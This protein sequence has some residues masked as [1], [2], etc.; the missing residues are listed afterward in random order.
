[1]PLCLSTVACKGKGKKSFLIQ[2]KTHCFEVMDS[3]FNQQA[4]VLGGDD[5]ES[6]NRVSFLFLKDFKSTQKNQQH[7]G[8]W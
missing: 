5:P 1:M 6:L 7:P 3:S 8:N 4:V 2:D